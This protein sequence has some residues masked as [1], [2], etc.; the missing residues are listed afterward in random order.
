MSVQV[1]VFPR[2][3]LSE[4][5]K[6]ALRENGI[7]PVEADDPKQVVVVVPGAPM[8]SA[9]DLLLA[10]LHGCSYLDGS[11]ARFGFELRRRLLALEKEQKASEGSTQ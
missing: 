2:G 6:A 11:M 10:A 7:V 5:D 8:A 4:Q 3:Q 1:I 9:N